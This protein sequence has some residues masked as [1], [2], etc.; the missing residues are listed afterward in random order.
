M[1]VEPQVFDLLLYR[2]RH[3][4]RVVSKDD[5][6]ESVWTGRIVSDSA[7]NTRITAA[8]VALGDSGQEQR[9]IRTLPRKGVRFVGAVTESNQKPVSAS[10]P[11]PPDAVELP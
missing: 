1:A 6:I 9:L 3:R 4:D 5:L 8:R 10:Q 7:L 11:S 2:V